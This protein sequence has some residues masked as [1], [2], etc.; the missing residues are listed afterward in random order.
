MKQIILRLIIIG[1]IIGIPKANGEPLNQKSENKNQSYY[2]NFL[3]KQVNETQDEDDLDELR[4]QIINRHIGRIIYLNEYE[5]YNNSNINIA[6]KKIKIEKKEKKG[7]GGEKG[8]KGK[9]G[10]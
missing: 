2:S 7:K 9:R 4:K 8:K 10:K 1:F 5:A 6:N 3:S